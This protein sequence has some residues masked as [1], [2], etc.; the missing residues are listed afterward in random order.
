MYLIQRAHV[1]RWTKIETLLKTKRNR[2]WK[3]PYTVLERLTLFFNS[4]KNRKLKVNLWWA[5]ACKRKKGAF[6][7][8]FILSEGNFFII[9]VLAQC[10]VYWIQYAYFYISKNITL[11][12][13]LLVFNIV[14]S[15]QCIL[16]GFKRK[17]SFAITFTPL[18][19]W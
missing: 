13:F 18:E 2:K 12:T 6:F 4:Y 1:F 3:I 15:L 7:V 14:K 11:Y 17:E 9:C 8:P 5:G 16:K 10:I 19:L